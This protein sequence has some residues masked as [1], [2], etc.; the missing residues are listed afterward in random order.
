M[1]AI[2]K[3]IPCVSTPMAV[4]AWVELV[5][6]SLQGW[7][8]ESAA[9]WLGLTDYRLDKTYHCKAHNEH[10]FV[11][12]E[13]TDEHKNKLELRTGRAVVQSNGRKD[14]PPPSLLSSE[15]PL[16]PSPANGAIT[17]VWTT[18]SE[19][20]ASVRDDLRIE[21]VLL[22]PYYDS[23]IS[24][25]RHSEATVTP[26]GALRH[27][28]A[29]PELFGIRDEEEDVSESDLKRHFATNMVLRIQG[30]PAHCQILKTI[31][32]SGDRSSHP[33]L[34][35]V[36]IL[37]F[38]VNNDSF[39][40]GRKCYWF[41]D[42]IF[43]F[44]EKWAEIHKNGRV[45]MGKAKWGW[46]QA[47]TGSLGA[48]TNHCRELEHITKVWGNFEEKKRTMNQQKEEYERTR[49][50][51]IETRKRL[52]EQVEALMSERA[53]H[54]REREERE[55]QLKKEQK[56][57]ERRHQEEQRLMKQ[58]LAKLQFELQQKDRELQL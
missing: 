17:K 38:V 33:S 3:A 15:P 37:T 49:T 29:V 42:T 25:S 48:V 22:N 44:L 19:H 45:V 12:Y 40:W 23:Q 30:H 34:W 57:R 16:T 14:V 36:M 8:S 58:E 20:L 18:V 55:R 47:S 31:T 9:L 4:V 1:E 41:T 5:M 39:F 10:E 32:F 26:S 54:K 56:E 13:F 7:T 46:S 11:I 28:L 50:E 35:D 27:N 51:E 24:E 6:A 53:K 43:G 2:R 52:A 21:N